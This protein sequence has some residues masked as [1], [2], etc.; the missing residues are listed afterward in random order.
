MRSLSTNSHHQAKIRLA[1][2]DFTDE[3]S[4]TLAR[5]FA[6]V[7]T[8]ALFGILALHAL[9]EWRAMRVVPGVA[10]RA[11]RLEW[12]VA[13]RSYPAFAVSRIDPAEK[14]VSYTILR[15]PQGGRKDVLHWIGPDEAPVAEL[16]IYRPGG[17]FDD[18]RPAGAYPAAR[19]GTALA[20]GLE[21]AGVIDSKFGAVAL[22]RQNGS[23]EGGRSCLGFS[24]RLDDPVVIM[25]GWSCQGEKLPARR[26]AIAC[27][28]DHLTLLTSG[29]EPKLA[30]LFARAELK[31]GTRCAGT[32]TSS[33]WANSIANPRLRGA[34]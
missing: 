4:G 24:K 7:G 15:H 17:E 12:A 31:R 25:S 23:R 8:L 22:K 28:L 20:A 6:Y 1:L 10:Q 21:E 2:A 30:E 27:M 19:I 3:I 14:S 29:N 11:A 32:I 16:K 26:A 13:D 9:D 33:D 18:N 5:L 34:L